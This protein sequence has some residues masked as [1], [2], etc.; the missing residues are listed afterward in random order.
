MYDYALAHKAGTRLINARCSRGGFSTNGGTQC[1]EGVC[2]IAVQWGP[3]CDTDSKNL[4]NFYWPV[5][6]RCSWGTEDAPPNARHGDPHPKRTDL[7]LSIDV[8]ED[9]L[10][11]DWSGG[12]PYR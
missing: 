2:K 1:H 12:A 6:E 3:D 8:C 4:L 10:G 7:P 9:D 11:A 5:A